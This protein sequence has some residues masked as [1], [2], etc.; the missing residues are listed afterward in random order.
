ME[1]ERTSALCSVGLL[2][3]MKPSSMWRRNFSIGKESPLS[4]TDSLLWLRGLL[5]RRGSF[6]ES[7][8]L[9]ARQG[10]LRKGGLIDT[11]N[12]LSDAKEGT[13][14]TFKKWACL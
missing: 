5:S 13:V 1:L 4:R 8:P 6:P 11:E 7:R 2:D 3:R 12:G 9:L 10:P 14:F